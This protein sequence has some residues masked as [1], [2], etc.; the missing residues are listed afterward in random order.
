MLTASAIVGFK[1]DVLANL[2]WHTGGAFTA[3]STYMWFVGV[4]FARD[5]YDKLYPLDG[6]NCDLA[7]RIVG[8]G[9]L[10]NLISQSFRHQWQQDY[11]G[12]DNLHLG[13]D[14]AVRGVAMDD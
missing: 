7:S 5:I 12:L 2:S 11:P 3:F 4:D 9:M 6:S 10:I 1:E 14:E 13:L 8:M